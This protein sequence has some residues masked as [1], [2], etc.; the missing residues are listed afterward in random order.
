[1]LCSY[2]LFRQNQML[3]LQQ[4]YNE[5]NGTHW[6]LRKVMALPFLPHVAIQPMFERLREKVN[7]GPIQQLM[8]YVSVTW[9]SSTIWPPS[10]W[11]IFMLS[12]RTNNDVEGWHHGLHRRTWGR[13][14][15]P[16]YMFVGLLYKE[17]RFTA[18]QMRLV[19]EKKL[20]RIQ[21][22]KYRFLQEKIFKTWDKF[23]VRKKDAEQLLRACAHLNGPVRAN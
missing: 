20:P 22:A 14:N 16:F 13:A 1:M 18:I 3:G 4:Q 12:V 17:A 19:S 2:A 15:L 8:E 10:S 5:D 23:Q 7:A 11:S 9:I 21:R 6:F